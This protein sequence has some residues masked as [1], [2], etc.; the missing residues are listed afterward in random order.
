MPCIVISC[1]YLPVSLLGNLLG[2][3][4]LGGK[5]VVLGV[6]LLIWPLFF[7]P[8]VTPAFRTLGGPLFG[9]TFRSHFAP[10]FE[11]VLGRFS[12]SLLGLTF[13]TH[14]SEPLI[15]E[16][17]FQAPDSRSHFPVAARHLAKQSRKA[18]WQTGLR[19]PWRERLPRKPKLYRTTTPGNHFLWLLGARRPI[20]SS[21]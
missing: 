5:C 16:A 13:R 6:V 4:R 17:S 11:L 7:W 1:H 19:A 14:F 18:A 8:S 9:L 12:E 20:Q 10:L 15:R 2:F 3:R 21:K